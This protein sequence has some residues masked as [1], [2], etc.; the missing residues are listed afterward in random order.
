[1]VEFQG[2]VNIN[3]QGEVV[4]FCTR[5]EAMQ[6]KCICRKKHDCPEA[7][8]NI[9]VLP[10]TRPSER[11]VAQLTKTSEKVDKEVN[12]IKEGLSKLEKAVKGTKF[13]I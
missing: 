11:S 12:K 6:G 9:E 3:A 13:R 2:I 1:M 7:I 4:C 5:E 10:G 8:I